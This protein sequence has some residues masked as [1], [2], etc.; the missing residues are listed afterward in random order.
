MPFDHRRHRR[1]NYRS[2]A[3]EAAVSGT[4]VAIAGEVI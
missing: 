2:V 1:A 3:D 4:E